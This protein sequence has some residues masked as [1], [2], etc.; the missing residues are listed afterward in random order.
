MT[1]HSGTMALAGY[2]RAA[3]GIGGALRLLLDTH[4]RLW[5]LD[6]DPKLSA[7]APSQ[8]FSFSS[9]RGSQNSGPIVAHPFIEPKPRLGC[10]RP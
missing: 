7:R 3:T 1:R 8:S 4:A 5:W 2:R 9:G 10:S 6:G